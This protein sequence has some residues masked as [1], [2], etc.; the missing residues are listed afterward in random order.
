MEDMFNKAIEMAKKCKIP[1]V[2]Y[3]HSGK[4]NFC[5]VDVFNGE[6]FEAVAVILSDG[7]FEN[8]DI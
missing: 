8:I 2:I 6:Y 5:R 4:Y 7:T 3:R 1:V